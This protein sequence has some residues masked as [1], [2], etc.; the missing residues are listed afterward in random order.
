MG[1]NTLLSIGPGGSIAFDRVIAVGR[2]ESAPIRR[3]ARKAKDEGRLIDL[4][5]GKAS[6]WVYFMD[7]GHIILGTR[8]NELLFTNCLEENE[9]ERDN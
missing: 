1:N 2:W 4:T 6:R 8:R 5:Y 7:S 3:A 9:N